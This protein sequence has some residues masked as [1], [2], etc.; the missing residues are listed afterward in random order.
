MV[1][2]FHV[3]PCQMPITPI[4]AVVKTARAAGTQFVAETIYFSDDGDTTAVGGDAGTPTA[5]LTITG[6][7]DVTV[8]SLDTSDADITALMVDLLGYTGTFTVTGGSPAFD[9]DGTGTGQGDTTTTLTVEGSAT[10]VMTLASTVTFDDAGT[11]LVNEANVEYN[12]GSGETVPYAG[13]S[14]GALE[15]ID[16]QGMAGTLSLGVVSQVNSDLFTLEA[17]GAGQVLGCIGRGLDDGVEEVPELSATGVWT[18]NGSAGAGDPAFG[19]VSNVDLEIKEVVFNTGGQLTLNNVDLCISGDVDLSPLNAADLVFTGA[20]TVAVAAG[21][22]LTLSVEQA[23]AI[24]TAFPG[25]TITGEGTLAI[26]GDG[27]DADFGS[28]LGTG[29]VDMSGVTISGADAT[30]A[31]DYAVQGATDKNG[32]VITQTVIGS[33]FNDAVDTTAADDFDS[34]TLDVILRL[35]TDTGTI[36][37]PEETPTANT[38]VD[39][40]PE[41]AGDVITRGSENLQ[42]EVDAGFDQVNVITDNSGQADIVQVASGAEFYAGAVDGSWIADAGSSND[43]IA[44]IEA[45][46]SVNEDIDVSA[47]GG[48]NGWTLIGAAAT[49]GAE[50]TLVGSD[51]DDVLIDGSADDADNNGEE[52][53]HTGNGGADTFFFNLGT[54]TPAT[55]ADVENNPAFDEETITVDTADAADDGTESIVIDYAIGNLLGSLTVNDLTFGSDIDFSSL[56]D[57]S[58]AIASML[59]AIGGIT[60]TSDGVDTVTLSGDNGAR[61]NVSSIG[62]VGATTL[63]LSTADGT[64]T[65]QD[66]TVTIT[67]TASAGEVYTLTV[68]LSE[69]TDIT[70]EFTAAGGESATAIA[71]ALIAD[72]NA[73]APASTV[74][75]AAGGGA[76]EI[77][78]TDEDPDNGGFEVTVS[79][80]VSAISGSSASSLL[81]GG[82][83]YASADIDVITDFMDSEGDMIDFGLAEG[84]SSNYGEDA[85]QADFATAQA[86]ADAEFAADTDLVYF[87]TGSDADGVG[88]LFINSDGDTDADTVVAMVGVNEGNFDDDNIDG[89]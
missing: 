57:V 39:A 54:T 66:N 3:A 40:T 84:S 85:S 36:G 82:E 5:T 13:V 31:V 80:G 41:E 55:F 19:G 75:A 58:D 10:S 12:V 79:T 1:I 20:V 24:A 63:A 61:M 47:A 67:G 50:N 27:D 88:L 44:V 33:T 51:Q 43:G 45:D 22:T 15:L 64:D 81:V 72:F 30:G 34:S 52:D 29:T 38:P 74:L 68:M 89:V 83:T 71:A 73:T 48:A 21:A 7:N 49:T 28:L 62:T 11:P 76:G 69:G 25:F 9:G 77:D 4:T 16:A 18:V 59:D 23:D 42:I 6:E 32:D 86:L 37:V 2:Q 56:V 46:G 35:G 70:A 26:V 60:A 65:T 53:T 14:S 17:T 78:L 87:L 8:K